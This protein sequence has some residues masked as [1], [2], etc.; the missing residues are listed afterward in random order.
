MTVKPETIP[1]S[2]EE[3]LD[4]LE[5]NVRKLDVESQ[6]LLAVFSVLAN[7]LDKLMMSTRAMAGNM[8]DALR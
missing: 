6:R 1:M 2:I 7:D 3:R 8:F 4:L 5:H